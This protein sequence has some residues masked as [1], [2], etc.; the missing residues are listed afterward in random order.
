MNLLLKRIPAPDIPSGEFINTSPSGLTQNVT[1]LYAIQHPS[2]V[3]Y[4]RL[5]VQILLRGLPICLI[6]PYIEMWESKMLSQFSTCFFFPCHL[7]SCY[8][9]QSLYGGLA[10]VLKQTTT[11]MNNLF[12][13][14]LPLYYF[15]SWGWH[16]P[17]IVGFAA[18]ACFCRLCSLQFGAAFGD[19]ELHWIKRH[20][21]TWNIFHVIVLVIARPFL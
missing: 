11:E 12:I 16:F 4:E 1:D 7:P 20:L 5:E 6:W 2:T 14:L 8:Q 13:Y 15:L 18:R 10:S 9:M 3:S 21:R 19:Y 17:Q